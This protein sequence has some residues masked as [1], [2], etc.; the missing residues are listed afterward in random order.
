MYLCVLHRF[1]FVLE[2]SGMHLAHWFW[3]SFS[4]GV[5]VYY[6]NSF[7]ILLQKVY[8]WLLQPEMYKLWIKALVCWLSFSSRNFPHFIL[9]E[10]FSSVQF[11]HS[12]MPDSLWPL[13]LQNAR[14]SCSSQ[15]LGACLNSYPPSQ[16]CHPTISS[17]VVPSPP[18]F[19]LSQH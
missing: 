17:S 14:L 7:Q 18:A 6:R 15:T 5:R 19:N 3:T 9:R 13:R 1:Y 10:E 16:W 4:F 8:Q 2:V 11:S 12:V